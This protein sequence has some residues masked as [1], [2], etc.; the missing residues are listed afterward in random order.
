[1]EDIFADIKSRLEEFTTTIH[2]DYERECLLLEVDKKYLD[3]VIKIVIN[4]WIGIDIV[5]N[6]ELK[7]NI[8]T[9]VIC[10]DTTFSMMDD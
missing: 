8:I 10:A 4:S 9:I 2:I 5:F 7:N 6:K 3:E 1:M